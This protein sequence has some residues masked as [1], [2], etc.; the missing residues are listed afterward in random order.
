[1]TDTLTAPIGGVCTSDSRPIALRGSGVLYEAIQ[2][3]LDTRPEHLAA[4]STSDTASSTVLVVVGEGTVGFDTVG[5]DTVAVPSL[6]VRWE[7]GHVLLGPARLPGVPGC[8]SCAE[9]RRRRNRPDRASYEAVC[10]RFGA[11]PV[12]RGPGLLGGVT[13]DLLATLV[14]T[15]AISLGRDPRSARTCNALLKVAVETARISWH[16]VLPDPLCPECSA[17]PA[18][19]PE[20]ARIVLSAVRKPAPG[21]FRV[22]DAAAA[23]P[24]LERLYTDPET[25][26]VTRVSSGVVG[27]C[28]ISMATLEPATAK[29]A[30]QNGCGRALSFRSARLSALTEALERYAGRA[31]RGRRTT[32]RARYV[33]VTDRAVD[34]TTFG[35]FPDERHDLPEFPYRRYHPER[36][37]PWV[38]GYSFAR[39]E[40]VLVPENLAYYARGSHAGAEDFIYEISNGCALGGCLAEAIIHGL[41]EVTERDAFLMTW[42]AQL[43]APRVD[44]D[45]AT[46]RAIPLL[47][48]R[49]RQTLGYDILAFDITLEHGIPSFWVLAVDA[50]PGPSRLRAP[51]LR[52]LCAANAHPNP[53]HALL[54]ALCELTSLLDGLLARYSE[55][56][57]TAAARLLADPDE[58]RTMDHHSLLYSHPEAF[59]R[60]S[61]LPLG[62]PARPLA[63][64][65]HQWRWPAHSDLAEDLCEL[66]R[67]Y[68]NTGLD[69]I[70][71]NQTTPEH[72]AG[73]LSCVKVLIPGALPMTFGHRFRRTEGIPRLLSVPR[74]LGYHV[75][76]LRPDQINSHPHPFP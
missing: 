56:D 33:D 54:G 36:E 15:E 64:L 10:E 28:A 49:A 74:L 8:P 14:A 50:Q 4:L 47:A 27:G 17:L 37:L 52:A 21:T 43:P 38:W 22:R 42:Y 76:D 11:E 32:V 40:P 45:S 25:G 13:A 55:Q 5:F 44:L 73:G 53:E 66:V 60:F 20:A 51:R 48:E 57:T 35:L 19:T 68:L 2:F 6:P 23:Q 24:A 3:G 18:D 26:V 46:D 41:L 63:D 34:P 61:F 71:V 65:A 29:S 58:V 39:E 9:Q 75:R 69:V 59:D 67:R 62:G 7:P 1:M 16:R 12:G 72:Q 30:S 70:V 31:P